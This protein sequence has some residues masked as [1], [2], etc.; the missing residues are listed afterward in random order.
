MR[1]IPNKK[2]KKN[3]RKKKKKNSGVVW[4]CSNTDGEKAQSINSLILPVVFCIH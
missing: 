1:K 3:K 2:L 4:Q